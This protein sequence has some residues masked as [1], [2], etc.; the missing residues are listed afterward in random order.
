[1]ERETIWE[2]NRARSPIACLVCKKAKRPCDREMPVLSMS[3]VGVELFYP[4][5]LGTQTQIPYRLDF[6]CDY[7]VE[8]AFFRLFQPSAKDILPDI[9]GFNMPP[10]IEITDKY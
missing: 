6:G 10:D 1:L 3:K 4:M 2:Q 8:L 5:A 9:G 7:S